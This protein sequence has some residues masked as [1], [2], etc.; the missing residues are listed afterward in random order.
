VG[1]M[2]VD[3][4]KVL[5]LLAMSAKHLSERCFGVKNTSELA[6]VVGPTN[7]RLKE[8]GADCFNQHDKFTFA[9]APQQWLE[10]NFC[11]LRTGVRTRFAE[12]AF[13]LRTDAPGWIRAS[14]PYPVSGTGS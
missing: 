5:I 11:R 7:L 6:S 2:G 1:S 3:L 10:Y 9:F 13:Y 14:M 4:A 12:T 8:A